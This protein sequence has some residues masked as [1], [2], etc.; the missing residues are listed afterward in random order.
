[1]MRIAFFGHNVADAA[2]RRRV[3]A[4][5]ADGFSVRGFMARRGPMIDPGWETVD[6]GETR[7]GAFVHRI[8]SVFSGADRAAE[9]PALADAEVIYARNL[10]M[11]ATAFLAKRKRGLDTPVIYE[12]LDV[13]RLMVRGDPIGAGLRAIERALLK[14]CKGLVVSSPGF[15]RNYFE[16]R[17]RGHFHAHLIENRLAEGMDYGPR[18]EPRT[19][20]PGQPLK[21]GWVGILRCG[22][23]FKLLCA[24]ADAFPSELEIHLHGK[25]AHN[26]IEAFDSHVAQRPNLTYHGPYKAPEDLSGIYDSI[27]VVWA[28]D[29]MEAG[30]NSVWLLPNRIYEGGYYA[31]P[32]I[33]PAGTETATWIRAQDTGLLVPEPLESTLAECVSKLISDRKPLEDAERQLLGLPDSVFIQP[34]GEMARLM[35][36]IFDDTPVGVPA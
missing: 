30:Y 12:C 20:D 35:A 23:S 1:M 32:P 11:L 29:F 7:D 17:H 31:T 13:H 28:G 9:D 26:E 10:D 4:F 24:L 6:L 3:A 14:R 27:D 25:P 2:I 8:R 19:V 21:L 15:V 36:A 33:A 16:P 5:E 34:K 22:R 18:P